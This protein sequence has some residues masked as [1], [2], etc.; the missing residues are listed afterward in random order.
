M[1]IEHQQ[2]VSAILIEG[3]T[4]EARRLTVMVSPGRKRED[5]DVQLN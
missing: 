4:D 2:I 5:D 1:M 3:T